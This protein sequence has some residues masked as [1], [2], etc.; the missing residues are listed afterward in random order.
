MYFSSSYQFSYY[1]KLESLTM[2]ITHGIGKLLGAGMLVAGIILVVIGLI[3]Y[4]NYLNTGKSIS[5]WITVLIALGI[6]FTI[7]GGLICLASAMT[8]NKMV[9]Y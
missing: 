3:F 6:G 4:E 2:A 1:Y 8:N 7:A 9:N 5:A